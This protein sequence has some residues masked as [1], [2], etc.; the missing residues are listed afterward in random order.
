[1]TRG[2]SCAVVNCGQLVTLAGPARPRIR[3]ELKNLAII[4]NGAMAIRDGLI[5][6]VGSSADIQSRITPQHQLID[7][8][9]RVV[10]PGFVD[11]HTHAVFAGTR[12][13]EYELRAAG[14]TYRQIAEQGGGIR[15]TVR[16]TRAANE[17][18]LVQTAQRHATWFLRTGAT[19]LEAKSGYGLSL[20]DELKLLAVIR[21]FGYVPTFLGAHEIPDEYR[22]KTAGYV[23]LIV[24][25]MLPAIAH[26]RLAEYCD[27]F[28]EPMV[29]DVP[30]ARQILTAAQALGFKLRVH[31]DQ[32]SRSGAAELAAELGAA[33]ADHLEHIDQPG[34]DALAR[35]GVQP[36]LLPASVYTL[37]S[38]RF[39]P[40]RKMI[41]AGLALVLATDFNPGSSPTPSIPFVLSLAS[42]HM[43]LTPAEAIAAVTINAA[44]S[45]HRG[46]QIGSLEPGKRADFVIH[47]CRDYREIA[48]FA[49]IES[50]DS[51]YIAGKLAFSRSAPFPCN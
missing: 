9:G 20:P 40:A 49:G 26:A 21:R 10:L 6:A 24:E 48:Y 37:G 14:A 44:H 16:K 1:M 38:S 46:A 15:S 17:D 43:R 51:V 23:R 31:A 30:S 33:T 2:P 27:V 50:P 11:A 7:A 22:G 28:C 13:D 41:D 42:T 18:E 4:S 5:E 45:L 29:F 32:L 34:I 12:V 36:V 19:T 35:A 3:D 39:A 47:D 25:E 8:A